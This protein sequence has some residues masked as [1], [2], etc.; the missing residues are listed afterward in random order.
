MDKRRR[1]PNCGG[2]VILY[3]QEHT[4][5]GKLTIKGKREGLEMLCTGLILCPAEE[6]LFPGFAG[7]SETEIARITLEA[8]QAGRLGG[9]WRKAPEGFTKR[10]LDKIEQE[11]GQWIS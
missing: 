9:E 10:L 7:G 5:D 4:K 8:W 2:E 11:F 1:C 6:I 3:V